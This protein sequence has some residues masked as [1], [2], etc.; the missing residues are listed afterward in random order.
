MAN[1]DA[2]EAVWQSFRD[3]STRIIGCEGGMIFAGFA[4]QFDGRSNAKAM[5]IGNLQAQFS[6]MA[7]GQERKGQKGNSKGKKLAHDG[8]TS[9]IAAA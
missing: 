9:M 8:G 5:G 4:D 6:G 7:L 2:I 1:L 3:H